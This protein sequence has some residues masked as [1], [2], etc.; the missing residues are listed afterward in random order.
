MTSDATRRAI[1]NASNPAVVLRPWLAQ[2]CVEAAER[3]EDEPTRAVLAAVG[4]PYGDVG[5]G[6]K[7]ALEEVLRRTTPNARVDAPAPR[8]WRHTIRVTNSS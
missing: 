2:W 1:M 6:H 3:G 8:R 5:E 7:R 4:Q